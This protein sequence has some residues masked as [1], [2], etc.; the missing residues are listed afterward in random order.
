M[1]NLVTDVPGV[2]VGSAEDRQ[3]ATGVTAVVFEEPAVA[4]IAVLG[5]APGLRDTGLLEPEMTV[6]RVDA[7]LLS[8]GSAFGLDAAGGAMAALAARGRGFAVGPA[9]VPIVPQAILFDLL[10]GGDKPWARGEGGAPPYRALGAAAVEAAGLA[11]ALG[12]AGAGFGATTLD[13]KGGLGS[14]SAVLGDG[15]RVGAV[16]AVNAVGSAVIGGGPHFWAAP[17]ERGA[18]FG[19]LGWPAAIPAAALAP[20]FKG[21]PGANTTI[22]LVATDAVLTK[23]QAKRLAIAAH[24]GFARALRPAHA[25]LDGDVVFSAATGRRPLADPVFGLAELCLA[26]ADC[27][28]RAIAR[29]VHA[30]TALDRPGAQPAWRD[31]FGTLSPPLGGPL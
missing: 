20:R 4:S 7:I 28:A 3:G 25:P 18:E 14:A 15:V 9:R 24:D 26:A 8:G 30:A 17:Y 12:T 11:F 29:G 19:G 6:E 23:A 10:N 13:L 21:G 31:R 16:V 22:A 1:R 27:L 2:L 5:G